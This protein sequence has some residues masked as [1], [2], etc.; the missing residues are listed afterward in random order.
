[1]ADYKAGNLT[2][3]LFGIDRSAEKTITNVVNKLNLLQRSLNVFQK[4]NAT[5]VGKNLSASFYNI[6]RA[7]G[8]INENDINKLSS[9]AKATNYLQ[10]FLTV[11]Q[12]SDSRQVYGKLNSLFRALSSSVN[13][14]DQ[15]TLS[16]ITAV[17]SALSSLG[18]FST[19]MTKL[20]FAKTE[21]GFKNLAVAI[22]PFLEK[23]KE[24]EAGLSSL[25]GIL[26]K[27]SGNK[28]QGLL[29]GGNRNQNGGLFGF[30]RFGLNIY[31][32]RRMGRFMADLVQA[33]SDYNETLNLWQ[34]A[35]RNN[36]DVAEQFVNKMQKAYGIS[37]KT[38]M[39]AQAIFKNMIG[40]LGQISDQTAYALSEALVQMSADF[41][42]LYNVTIESAF[43]KMQSM[44][45]GQVRPIRS[46]GLDMTET[47]LFMFYQQLGGTKT[48]RQLNRTEKQLLSILAVYQQMS[49][50]GA[51][52]DMSKTLN[53][54]ANQSRMMTEYWVELKT[55]SGLLL[56]DLIDQS[57]M[58]VHIN[59]LL[60]TATEIIKAIAKSRG[61]GDENYLTGIFET[62]DATND[63]VDELQGKL[64]DFDK[65]RSL[66][67][68]SATPLAIDEKLLEAITGYSS[69]IDQAENAAQKLAETWLEVL[70]FTKGADGQL[71]ITAE[72]LDDIENKFK[73]ILGITTALTA[74]LF[75]KK[76]FK[77]TWISAIVAT[78][79][80]GYVTNEKFADSVNKLGKAFGTALMPVLDA[81]LQVLPPILDAV[82]PIVEFFADFILFLDEAKL[83][84]PILWG[85][86]SAI[87]TIKALKMK[88]SLVKFAFQLDGII[89]KL[90]NMPLALLKANNGLLTTQKNVSGLSLAFGALSLTFLGASFNKFVN[91]EMSASKRM[92][93]MF[94]AVAGAITAAA[95]AL[96]AFH[97]DWVGALSL[98]GIVAGSVFTVSTAI[99]NYEMGASDIDSGTVFRAGEF[100][101]TEAV[102][103]GSNGK[104]NVANI[105][106]MKTAYNQALNEWWR[107]ARNDIPAFQGVS[108][109]GIYTIVEG[110]ARRRGKTFS[111]V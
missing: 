21:T 40:S 109:N 91:T 105:Q 36:L 48:M 110:E 46:A 58:L 60:I 50:A 73:S 20:D 19:K 80:Y 85:I 84:E 13:S 6:S 70:G 96:K 64:L 14:I 101:K 5:A 44:L 77:N 42:S 24:A 16:N 4:V 18:R 107:S 32:M 111:K 103:T 37:T 12:K 3:E 95:V 27:S 29:G 9:L 39:N 78:I 83:L 10:R 97:M 75:T 69:K 49:S 106:Q 43:E 102:Y 68:A 23:V 53:Q 54:F 93:T 45:A 81:V 86:L 71:E 26:Q 34:V 1:M 99:P 88:D 57:G 31:M 59:A 108:D 47:T 22:Q 90:M 25:Y 28:I 2:L 11:V 66:E 94:L 74:F 15:T 30:A 72:K 52:G 92:V 104:T 33:G 87:V 65:F 79:A 98:A 38:L 55:W 56:K 100:G 63:E 62:A 17:S 76:A 51:L 41:A 82:T 7:L 8:S 89:Q 61:I 67:G 35:M